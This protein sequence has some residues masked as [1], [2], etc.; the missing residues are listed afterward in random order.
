[1]VARQFGKP[2]HAKPGFFAF[3]VSLEY[4]A[5]LVISATSRRFSTFLRI[6][7]LPKMLVFNFRFRQVITK[8]V[9]AKPLPS[10]AGIISDI[11]EQFDFARLQRIDKVA[12]FCAFVPYRK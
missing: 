9:L 7:Q 6:S 12:E 10:R 5:K 8:H 1:M 3:H 2:V 4:P 11:N